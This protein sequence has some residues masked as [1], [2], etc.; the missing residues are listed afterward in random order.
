MA[1]NGVPQFGAQESSDDNAVEPDDGVTQVNLFI[2][3][4]EAKQE[5]SI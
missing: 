3:L 4:L 5:L 1:L 2:S